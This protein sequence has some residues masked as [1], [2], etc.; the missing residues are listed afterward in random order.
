[1]KALDSGVTSPSWWCFVFSH[2]H[3]LQIPPYWHTPYTS[4]FLCMFACLCNHSRDEGMIRRN[5]R[6]LLVHPSCRWLSSHPTSGVI[7]PILD[8]VC[9]D[10]SSDHLLLVFNFLFHGSCWILFL[11]LVSCWILYLFLRRKRILE[12]GLVQLD[13][14][15]LPWDPHNRALLEQIPGLH[16]GA[17]YLP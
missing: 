2:I 1:M 7:C 6:S 14:I 11:F 16:Q 8:V 4:F 13:K 5:H 9:L 10:P 12:R 3:P 17:L 15:T